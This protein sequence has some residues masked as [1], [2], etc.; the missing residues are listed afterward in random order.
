LGLSGGPITRDN[1]GAEIYCTIFALAE[2]AHERDVLWAGTDD[3]LVHLSRDRGKK[4]QRVT[5]PELPEW[6]LVSVIEPSPHDAA[7]CY[8]AATAYKLD[9]TRPYLFKTSDYGSTWTR[10]TGGLP[11]SEFTRVVREDPHRRGLL[12]AGTETGV[13]VSLDDGGA[14]QRLRGNLPGAHIHDLIVKNTDLVVATHGRAF[15]ILDDL[16][17]LHQ[18]AAVPPDG[19]VHLF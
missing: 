12:Y 2:S 3:G 18:V 17:P 14:W 4:W 10:I 7:T 8:V 13:W 1:T 16:T 6:S 11:D 19:D 15:W 5:P 9:D